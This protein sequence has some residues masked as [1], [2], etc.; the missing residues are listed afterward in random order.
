MTK[1][2]I[3]LA[4]TLMVIN[5]IMTGAF[6]SSSVVKADNTNVVDKISITVPISCTLE[7][8]GM[9]THNATIN[10]GQYNS[11]IGETTLKAFCNDNEGFSIYAIGYTDNLN[12]KNVLTNSTLGSTHDIATGTAI[13]GDASNWAM[14]LTTVSDPAPTYPITIQNSFDSFHTVPD[15]YTLV[16]KRTAGTDIGQAAEGS[17]L[18]TTYQAY[19]SQTQ[20]AGTYTGQVKYTLV[21]PHNEATPPDSMLDVGD[22]VNAKMKNIANNLDDATNGTQDYLIKSIQITNTLPANF[23]PSEANTVS[24]P[25]SKYPIYIFFDNTGDAGI[26]YFY[27]EN[28]TVVMNPDSAFLFRRFRNLVDLSGLAD[29]DSS[30]VT[31]LYLAFAQDSNLTSL[32][33]LSD[34]DTSKVTNLDAVFMMDTELT[35][36]DGLEDWD[37][38]SVTSMRGL[39]YGNTGITDISALAD[40]DVS[41]VKDMAQTFEGLS[42][43]TSLRGLEDWDTSSLE[44]LHWTFRSD[45]ALT[46]I[47][48]LTNWDTTNLTDIEE[49]FANDNSITSI[50]AITNWNTSNITTMRGA[51]KWNTTLTTIDLSNW[52]TSKVTN[53]SAMFVGDTS[54]TSINISGW[55]TS[56]VVDMNSMF[57]VGESYA[58]N[59]QLTE[60]IGLGDL[61]TS[62]V[63]DMTCMFY[64]AG[65]MTHYDIANWDVSK[66]QSF[67]HMFTDN[68]KLESLDLSRWNVSSLKTIVNMFDDNYKLTT[69]GDVSH[70]NTVS[71]IDASGWLNGATS[72]V[73]INGTLDLSNW[74]TTNLKATEEM[75]RAVKLQTI[76]LSGWTFDSITNTAWEGAGSGI[77]YS[78]GTGM[79]IMFKDT[80]QLNTVYVS[81]AGLNS[82]NTAVNNGIDITNMWSGSGASG[83]TVKQ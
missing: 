57:N 39:F 43:L 4:P 73:G 83:F 65:Q 38:L 67:N 23:E 11:N 9:N 33:A 6:L 10:N 45:A 59:G 40:W 7:G 2:T 3:R 51:F 13:S 82:F 41:N 5:T 62:N 80:A 63:T 25:D 61:D 20:A 18:K 54:V 52:D 64:G 8:T 78:Y 77:Y 37:V 36:L 30:N 71:L 44:R 47:S 31:S 81:Q 72:F 53:M 50:S 55:D 22:T 70:W 21:H 14:K 69:I 75:F 49:I 60:I 58:G 1:K 48:A 32:S 42:G 12:G 19:I 56:S 28:D 17:T 68:S 34:W 29:W 74:N 46:D 15:T 66:V 79:D 35:D 24:T 27:T 16:A 26:M 76:D